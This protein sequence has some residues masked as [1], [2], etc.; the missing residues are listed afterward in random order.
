MLPQIK[1]KYTRNKVT[2]RENSK[3][4]VNSYLKLELYPRHPL[5]SPGDGRSSGKMLAGTF[6]AKAL[7]QEK[8]GHYLHQNRP[9]SR[10]RL[11]M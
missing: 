2:K 4:I 8:T 7:P 10:Q 3:G 6:L 5:P 9:D 11:S 1:P